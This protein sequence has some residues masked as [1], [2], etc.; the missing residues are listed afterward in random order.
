[1]PAPAKEAPDPTAAAH[2]DRVKTI[3]LAIGGFV[4]LALLILV[5]A[6][7]RRWPPRL[8]GAVLLFGMTTVATL[9][10][11]AD[12]IG[13]TWLGVHVRWPY[14]GQYGL[15]FGVGVLALIA[16]AAARGRSPQYRRKLTVGLIG[17]QTTLWTLQGVSVL[18]THALAASRI[19][20]WAAIIV[21]VAIAWDV[22]M[23]G[24]SMTNAGS[25]HVPRDTRV[26]AFFGYVILVAATVL[27][28]S[29]QRV[30]A[31]G[32]AA[33]ALFEPES[34]TQAALYRIAFPLAVL[35]F[36]L[37]FGREPKP[38]PAPTAPSNPE[39]DDAPHA[40]SASTA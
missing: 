12:S 19:S 5:A 39:G 34:V 14:V 30:V 29:A 2:S 25:K 36:L 18:Y 20:A 21:L 23:S 27:F 26:L 35:L 31:T 22:T 11:S 3:D 33:E 32:H 24:D 6:R 1:L 17:L 4:A 16:L 15:L 10:F 28:F 7:G 37:R 40:L 13:R 8:V 38:G 9:L